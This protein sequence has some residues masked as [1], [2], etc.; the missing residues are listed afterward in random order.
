M[1]DCLQVEKQQNLWI[2]QL[3]RP[4]K[5]NALSAEL[6]EALLAEISSAHA[7]KIPLLV[8]R[9]NGKNFS[10]GFDLA[11]YEAQSDGDLLLRFIRLEMLLSAI[12]NSASLTIA[13]AHG[14]NFGAGVDL[15]A[16]CKQRYCV[17]DST[18]RMPGLRFGLVLGTGRFRD[19]VGKRAALEILGETKSFS[20]KESERI[21]FAQQI[22]DLSECRAIIDRATKAATLFDAET[23]ARFYVA[24]D[25]NN[26][27]RDMAALS[28]SAAVPGLKDRI[29][30]YLNTR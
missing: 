14:K 26:A 3:N 9:G 15:F 19:I 22:A 18:F 30:E 21:G 6:V 1:T 8:F 4:Q 11:N 7:Q 5:M 27:D 16:A 12:A 25:N 28:R 20:A 13:F 29:R 24:L 2:F 10:A 23:R 17:S